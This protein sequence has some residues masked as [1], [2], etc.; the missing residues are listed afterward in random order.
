MDVSHAIILYP[1][2][3]DGMELAYTLQLKTVVIESRRHQGYCAYTRT[4]SKPIQY[5]NKYRLQQKH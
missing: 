5:T 4:I 2:R 3:I 1:D